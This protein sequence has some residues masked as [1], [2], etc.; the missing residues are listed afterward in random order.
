MYYKLDEEHYVENPFLAQLQQ[1]GWKIYRQSK[2]NPENV[3][4][5]LTFNSNGE[6]NYGESQKFRE[7]FKEVMLENVLAQ[8]IKKINPWIEEDQIKEVIR[9]I[10]TPQAN[11]LL[12][13]N[14]EI[15][16]LLLENTSV[17]ENRQTGEKSP[18]VRFIDFKNPE[19]NTF[20][21]ISQFKLNVPG[22]EKH[23]IPDIVLFINGLPLVVIECKSPVISDPMS[24]AIKQLMR[25]SNRRGEKEG[26]EK[27]FY[28]NAFMIATFNQ[29]AKYGTITSSP[30][31]FYEWKDPYPYSL[32]DIPNIANKNPTSQD[33]L[34]QGMLSKNNLLSIIR[35]FILFV[36]MT[37]AALKN[38][39]RYH[40]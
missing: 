3:K 39:P 16:D 31:H 1:L 4:E 21:A 24:E 14:K 26:N 17:Q 35:N 15:H 12:E 30:E 33:I 27:L 38:S 23:I 6:P 18:T 29:R 11:S 28:Y 13:A 9:K 37:K 8:S 19:N 36:E 22:T 20:I 7:T 5:I 2:D 10:T 25:Y 34:V 40:I 32:S